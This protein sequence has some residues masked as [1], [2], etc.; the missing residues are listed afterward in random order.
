MVEKPDAKSGILPQVYL[1]NFPCDCM[2]T[3]CGHS[4]VCGLK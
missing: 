1:E 3:G 4:S 2:L